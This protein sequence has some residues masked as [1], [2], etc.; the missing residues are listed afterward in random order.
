MVSNGRVVVIGIVVRPPRV[1]VVGVRGAVAH[2]KRRDH[3]PCGRLNE[4]NMMR[5]DLSAPKIRTVEV[6][7]AKVCASQ[8]SP[9]QVRTHEI[10]AAEVSFREVGII[11]IGPIKIYAAEI[12][13]VEVRPNQVGSPQVFSRPDVIAVNLANSI[14]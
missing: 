14:Y 4:R 12:C 7:A 2:R 6:A 13:F 11:E 9:A 3:L 5:I 8:V 10:G 1:G